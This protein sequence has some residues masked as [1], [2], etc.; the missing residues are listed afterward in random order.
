[1][2]KKGFGLIMAVIIAVIIVVVGVIFTFTFNHLKKEKEENNKDSN[3]QEENNKE[4]NI[5]EES[6]KENSEENNNNVQEEDITRKTQPYSVE[7]YGAVAEFEIF[8]NTNIWELEFEIIDA[9]IDTAFTYS[10]KGVALDEY[11]DKNFIIFQG[12]VINP[13]DRKST[14]EKLANWYNISL[15]LIM[16][17]NDKEPFNYHVIGQSN[18]NYYEAYFLD[19]NLEGEEDSTVYYQITLVIDSK[20][21]DARAT[22][23]LKDEYNQIIDTMKIK[24]VKEE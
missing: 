21:L 4:D 10:P 23:A 19:Y 6:N 2:S 18:T 1:M 11:P 7:I 16:Q 3:I 9:G 8:K 5:Q 14:E 13:K 24:P 22:K 17:V 20:S 15:P 12:R